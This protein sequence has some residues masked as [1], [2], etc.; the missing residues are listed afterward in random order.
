MEGCLDGMFDLYQELLGVEFR[1][2]RNPSIWHEEVKMFEV[3]QDGKLKG[4]FYLDLHPRE[5]K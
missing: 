4:R 2:V 1:R 5:N 3:Y